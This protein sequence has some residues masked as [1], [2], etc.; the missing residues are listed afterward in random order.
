[1]TKK[2]TTPLAVSHETGHFNS[3][4]GTPLYFQSWTP[5]VNKNNLKKT[6]LIF[7][8]GM[9]EH[10]GRYQYPVEYFTSKGY[11]VYAMDLRGH[12]KSHGRRAYAESM[13]ELVEDA[14]T[15][16]NHVKSCEGNKKFF[17]VGHSFGGQIVLNYT[18]HYPDDVDGVLVSSPNLR[19]K[20]P[21]HFLK[22]VMAPVLSRVFPR[23]ALGNDLDPSLVSHD[24]HV[25]KNYDKDP[26]V[27][28]KITAKLGDIVLENYLTVMDLAKKYKAPIFMMHAGDDLICCPTGTQD[29][30]DKIPHKKKSLKIYKGLYHEIFN[31]LDRETVFRDMEAWIEKQ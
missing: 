17:L 1:M 26:H 18:S 19:L 28:R 2:K 31:E 29:F 11:I 30:F 25:V 4:E 20:L 8:H 14:R 7:I 21:V 23:L 3:H 5:E 24:P 13:E 6:V 27:L 15:F 22:R 12:G 16:V 9:A 10:S